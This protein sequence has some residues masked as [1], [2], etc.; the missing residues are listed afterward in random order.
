MTNI[1]ITNI[2]S[3][4]S[5]MLSGMKN[6]LGHLIKCCISLKSVCLFF[7]SMKAI[8]MHS[9]ISQQTIQY[10]VVMIRNVNRLLLIVAM[11]Y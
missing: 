9:S 4:R 1:T 10:S 3:S 6:F 2:T 5:S 8:T 11:S 7:L